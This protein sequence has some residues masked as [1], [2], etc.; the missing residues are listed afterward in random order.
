[1]KEQTTA[2]TIHIAHTYTFALRRL[3]SH[4]P[5]TTGHITV[6]TVPD[7]DIT[8]LYTSARRFSLGLAQLSM[9]NQA[10]RPPPNTNRLKTIRKLFPCSWLFWTLVPSS[11][12]SIALLKNGFMFCIKLEAFISFWPHG[13]MVTR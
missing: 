13:V 11:L 9:P 8:D 1:M 7:D 6:L 10:G 3:C 5:D 2:G 12:Y 4:R